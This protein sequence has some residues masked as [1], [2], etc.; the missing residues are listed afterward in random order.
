MVE[1][2]DG[3]IVTDDL[4][5]KHRSKAAR[6]ERDSTLKITRIA[7]P[8]EQLQKLT[9]PERILFLL[10]GMRRTRSMRFGSW[11]SSPRMRGRKTR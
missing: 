1:D 2:A 8:K 9:A 5:I 11:L 6:D 7:L 10:L 3:K 4:E